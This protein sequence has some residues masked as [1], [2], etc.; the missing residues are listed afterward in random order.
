MR[1]APALLLAAS[2]LAAGCAAGPA[3]TGGAFRN[4]SGG[5][6]GGQPGRAAYDRLQQRL[7]ARGLMRA[8]IAPPD[9]PFD[10]ET[11]VRNLGLVAFFPSGGTPHKNGGGGGDRMRR[12]E[13]PV[14]WRL[15]GAGFEPG[16][17]E[18][19]AALFARIAELSG[20]DIAEAAPGERENF[21]VWLTV[22]E[23]RDRVAA[24]LP[25][26]ARGAFDGWRRADDAVCVFTFDDPGGRLVS[27]HVF[28]GSE[29]TGLLRRSCFHEEIVQA[30][31]LVL[32]DDRVR[33][34]LFNDD[35]E[36]ALFTGHDQWL[37]RLLYLPG[38]RAGM[39][40]PEAEP[41]VRA[42]VARIR[43]GGGAI[44]P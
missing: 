14:R 11:L 9:A 6:A 25:P 41:V 37:M 16:D 44:P 5:E 31:G 1:L 3:A 26:R 8:D 30:M 42:G 13:G 43:P 32:D 33:P 24:T 29:V 22:P 28:I 2:L 19:V 35:E 23:E 12:W 17:R 27:A 40:W 38:L 20:L 10:N 34:S 4:A 36:F 15:L 18:E 21:A 7:I 39:G